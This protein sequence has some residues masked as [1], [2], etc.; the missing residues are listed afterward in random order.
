MT[1]NRDGMDYSYAFHRGEGRPSEASMRT[2][3]TAS[4]FIFKFKTDVN[5][6]HSR[7]CKVFPYIKNREI[8]YT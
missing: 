3:E 8:A 5:T 7:V 2:H 4:S 1:G 6:D